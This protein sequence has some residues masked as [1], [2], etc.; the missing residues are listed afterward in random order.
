MADG[1]SPGPCRPE[2][3]WALCLADEIRVFQATEGSTA[4][5]PLLSR[6]ETVLWPRAAKKSESWHRGVVDAA[7]RFMTTWHR[8]EAEQSCLHHAAVDAKSSDKGKA[9][10]TGGGRGNRTDAAMDE[11]KTKW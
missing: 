6:V 3:R 9:G 4:S 1:E 2:N 10:G 5:S 8:D 7:D 11:C